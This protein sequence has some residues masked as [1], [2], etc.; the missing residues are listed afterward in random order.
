MAALKD[1]MNCQIAFDIAMSTPSG[2]HPEF[3]GRQGIVV[4]MP[5]GA[6]QTTPRGRKTS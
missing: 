3:V 1:E 2:H 4:K 5:T 6:G